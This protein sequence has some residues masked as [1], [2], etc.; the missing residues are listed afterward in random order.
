MKPVAFAVLALLALGGLL[1]W[2][3]APTVAR[4]EEPSTPQ[5]IAP[6]IAAGDIPPIHGIAAWLNTPGEAPLTSEDLEGKVVLVHFWTFGCSNCVA[7]IPHVHAWYDRFHDD[8]FIILGVHTPEFSSEESVS[9]VR[10]AIARHDI[11]YPVLMDNGRVTWNEFRNR[12]WPADY[13]FDA[14]GKLI[15]THIGEGDYDEMADRIQT[16]LD[17]IH[18]RE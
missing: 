18:E 12:Y 4:A 11:P 5:E 1:W 9:N 3:Q 14:S 15:Y 7:T 16:A 10:K 8:D 2:S 17:A 6:P 13:L